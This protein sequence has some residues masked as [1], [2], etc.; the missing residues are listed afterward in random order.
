MAKNQQH[1]HPLTQDCSKS[2]PQWDYASQRRLIADQKRDVASA[3]PVDLNNDA[4]FMDT[5]VLY[6]DED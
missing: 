2:C 4:E 1:N 3:E 5:G 6:S